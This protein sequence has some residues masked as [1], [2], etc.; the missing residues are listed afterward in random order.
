MFSSTWVPTTSCDKDDICEGEVL[1]LR[2]AREEAGRRDV[3]LRP[4][5]LQQRLVPIVVRQIFF[6]GDVCP[7]IVGRH[8]CVREPEGYEV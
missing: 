3:N 1:E 6:Q 5:Y 2:Q 4:A 8:I 7:I